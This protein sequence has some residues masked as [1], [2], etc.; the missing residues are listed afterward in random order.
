MARGTV[1]KCLKAKAQRQG[2]ENNAFQQSPDDIRA[3]NDFP[4]F[5]EY[6]TRNTSKPLKQPAHMELWNELILTGEH[7]DD[8]GWIAGSNLDLLAPRGSAKST[9]LGLL[10]A[11]LI[12]KHAAIKKHLPILYISYNV[13]IARAK[14]AAIK[15]IVEAAEY[16]QIF[17]MVRPGR[18]WADEYWG[19]DYEFAGISMVGREPFTICCAGLK[20]GI[21]SKRSAL[22]IFDDIIKSAEDIDNPEIREELIENWRN[23]IKPTMFQGARAIC[24]GTRF[25]ADDIHVTTFCKSG[26]W[27]QIEQEALIED[28]ETG[29]ERSYWE[30]MWSTEYLLDLRDGPDGDPISFAFQYQNKILR[31]SQVSI[32]PTWILKKAPIFDLTQYD[33]V[34]VGLDLSSKKK[35]RNDFTVATLGARIKNEY[36]ILDMV[37]GKWMGN[38][39]KIDAIME[40]LADWGIVDPYETESVDNAATTLY[41]PTGFPCRIYGEDVQYQ[42]SLAGDWKTKVIQEWGIYEVQ[43][44]LSSTRGMDLLSHLRGVSG[45]FQN[46]MV[47]FNPY[48]PM[49]AAITEL[50]NFGSSSHDDCV[51]S[52]IHLLRGLR[53]NTAIESY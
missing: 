44:R 1:S 24:L 25:R 34:A 3:Q 36:H 47:Y 40:M 38:L 42:A 27:L 33:S 7:N 48:R 10:I 4:F 13:D 8:L 39:D 31:V 26:G 19:I 15:Q 22:V 21:T 16:T 5:C 51:A 29:V 43:Y 45:L 17:P 23:V 18:K 28:P 32:H 52:I 9:Y 30:E 50:V 49:G 11:W 41:L 35:Q 12:G 20:G 6:V 2:K 14:A 53:N 46:E 37:R